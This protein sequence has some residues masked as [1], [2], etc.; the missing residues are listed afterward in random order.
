MQLCTRPT[1]A[2]RPK[3]YEHLPRKPRRHRKAVEGI[4]PPNSVRPGGSSS[5]ILL[6]VNFFKITLLA[7]NNFG[8]TWCVAI[9]FLL[10]ER[11]RRS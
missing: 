7:K 8:A 3:S 10:K 9:W 2:R 6:C 11:E 5:A 4:G 1:G